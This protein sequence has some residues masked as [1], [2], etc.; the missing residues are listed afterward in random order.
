MPGLRVAPTSRHCPCGCSCY[1]SKGYCL[2]LDV[3]DLFFVCRRWQ[4]LALGFPNPSKY[5]RC[6]RFLDVVASEGEEW[7]RYRTITAPAFSEV[8]N[9]CRCCHFLNT[10]LR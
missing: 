5:I 8:R 1:Q 7:K 9:G 3:F 6:C 2:E 4:V 10:T